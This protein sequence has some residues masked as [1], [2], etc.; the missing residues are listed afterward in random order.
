MT[1][2]SATPSRRVFF[3]RILRF[4]TRRL[5]YQIVLP[6]LLLATLFAITG[7]YLLTS[8]VSQSVRDRLLLGA[9]R[10]GGNR[11]GQIEAEQLTSLRPLLFTEGLPGALHARDAATLG[12]LIL[13]AAINGGFDRV[14]VVATDATP[15]LDLI[16]APGGLLA[17]RVGAAPPPAPTLAALIRQ[18]LH[19]GPLD[20]TSAVVAS[21]AAGIFYT[22]GPVRRGEQ[23]VGA[24]VVGHDLTGVLRRLAG[25]SEVVGASF[26]G[27]DGAPLGATLHTAAPV[28]PL[29]PLPGA[30]SQ[31]I[32]ARAQ[33]LVWFRTVTVDGAAFIEAFGVAP[34]H[35]LDGA[36]P[37]VYG[38]LLSARSLDSGLLDN[39]WKL[40]LLFTLGL[41]LIVA[42]G[43]LLAR[44]ID[45][46]VAQLVRAS[47]QV[48]RGNLEVQVPVT[49]EDELGVLATQFNAMVVGLRQLLFVKDLFG[50]F[51]SP[52]V[53]DQLLAGQIALGGERRVVTIL[54]SDLRD[55]TRLSEESAPEAMVDLLNAYFR[56]V[57]R[58]ARAHGGI[59]NKFGG[60][61]TLII[62][63][64][65]VAMADHAD[66][67]LATALAMRAALENL[68]ARRAEEGAEPLRQGIGIN[69]GP[70]VAGQIGSEDRMEYTVIGDSVNLAA[71][72]QG[73][74]KDL[75]D[76]DIVFSDSTRAALA[77]PA[78][79]RWADL[80]TAPVRGK[81][82]AVALYSLLA[83]APVGERL[84]AGD[85]AAPPGAGVVVDVVAAG[86]ER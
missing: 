37:G 15:V 72:L 23:I 78:A 61:S 1:H 84:P 34:G 6:Y 70:V 42:I 44:W 46:P 33:E 66:R 73:I 79:W 86:Q 68:N 82:Q 85:A 45:R 13:P 57:V 25:T 12:K 27:P 41:V 20:K 60:D 51:V 36:P 29:A 2:A 76:C 5:R 74:T 24:V 35:G 56:A 49:R 3:V 22:A 65:P 39:L 53:S 55:F 80:G 63:G 50:R 54:F 19:P 47:E 16:A 31:E 28:A 38:V 26:Y 77:D 64:A 52:E 48:A 40:V 67:A 75:P 30:R 43:N 69:T 58:A 18:A 81:R 83:P 9:V 59:V 14:L 11:L 71:R 4:A 17:A 8:V 7:T 10:D 62:F 32:R 21:G